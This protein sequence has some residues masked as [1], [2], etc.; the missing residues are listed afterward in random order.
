ME[1]IAW[2]Q[3]THN[4]C[5]QTCVAMLT[6]TRLDEAIKLTG[7]RGGT[8]TV[9][10]VK[11]LSALGY[12]APPQLVKIHPV[13]RWPDT[14]V[15]PDPCIVKLTWTGRASGHW[16]LYHGGLFYDPSIGVRTP[17]QYAY[18]CRRDDARIT[19][20][21]PVHLASEKKGDSP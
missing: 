7:R 6:G 11:A 2:Q 12:E 9:D 15:L 13:V 19:S 21:L 14:A 5:G 4:T 3:Q 8:R 17:N 20:Y 10:L 18:L 1:Q 16:C